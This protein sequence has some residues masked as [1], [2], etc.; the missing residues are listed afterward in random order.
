[1]VDNQPVISAVDPY[2]LA[3]FVE[4]QEHGYAQALSEIRHGRKQSHWMWYV[5]PQFDG[6]GF[7]P[8]SRRYSIKS[9]AEAEAYLRHHRPDLYSDKYSTG[10]SA[11]Q[12]WR[13]T[14]CRT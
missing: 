1:M 6:L 10:T 7:S 9:I 12:P 4:A 8:A 3:R 2:D 13:E 11:D 14:R 5:F